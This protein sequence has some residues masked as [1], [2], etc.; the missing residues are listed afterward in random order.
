MQG[1]FH[2]PYSL[3]SSI[4]FLKETRALPI[5]IL[6]R[7]YDFFLILNDAWSDNGLNRRL[8]LVAIL[9]Y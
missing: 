5:F 8:K 4:Q 1:F 2:L 9:N 7:S 6:R 3:D